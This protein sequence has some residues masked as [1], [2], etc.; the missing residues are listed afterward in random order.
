MS[1]H[2]FSFHQNKNNLNK[3]FMNAQPG[4]K[5]PSAHLLR[6]KS[7]SANIFFFKENVGNT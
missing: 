7:C 6:K 4:R 2:F 3:L 1:V 5:H